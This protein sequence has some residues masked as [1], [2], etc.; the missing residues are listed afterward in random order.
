MVVIVKSPKAP[1]VGIESGLDFLIM[2]AV[3]KLCVGGV[4]EALD[5]VLGIKIVFDDLSFFWDCESAEKWQEKWNNAIYPRFNVPTT[6]TFL[7]S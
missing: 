1:K 6:V 4:D 2:S 5:A 3:E 7:L